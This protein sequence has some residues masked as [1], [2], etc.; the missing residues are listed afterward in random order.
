MFLGP[1]FGR[2]KKLGGVVVLFEELVSYSN[3]NNIDHMVIDTNLDNYSNKI[4]GFCSVVIQFFISFNKVSYVSLH[5]TARDFIYLAPIIVSISK[6]FKKSISLRKFAGN[7]YQIYLDSNWINKKSIRYVLNNADC[8]FFETNY[9]VDKFK[10]F[11]ANTFWWPNSRSKANKVVS[12]NFR[13]KFVFISQ[14]KKSKGIYELVDAASRLDN[15]FEFDIYGP[16]FDEEI[17]IKIAANSNTKYNGILLP[18]KVIDTL[19]NYDILILPTYHE[20]EGHPGIILEAFSLGMPVIST[21]WSSIP[22]IVQHNKNGL[23]VP[24]KDVDS[25]RKAV[26]HF[27]RDNYLDFR[28]NAIESFN[29]FDSEIVNMKYFERINFLIDGKDA[30]I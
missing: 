9:L 4:Y 11:N 7:F 1:R 19:V 8:L 5:G 28:L 3:M 20:G 15:S 18:E 16:T 25:L 12:E 23:L 14:V 26:L 13:K 10:C 6:V 29:Q 17:K 30:S 2:N 22:E 24:V 27:D 21:C